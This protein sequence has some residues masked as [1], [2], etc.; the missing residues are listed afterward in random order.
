MQIE[1]QQLGIFAALAGLIAVFAMLQYRPLHGRVQAAEQIKS[2]QL[3]AN[4][5]TEELTKKLP[6]LRSQLEQMQ[7]AVGNYEAKIPAERKIGAFLQE[8]AAVMDAHHLNDQVVQPDSEIEMDGLICIPV[9]IQC[10]GTMS[11]FFEFFKSLKNV[12]RLVRLEQVQLKNDTELSGRVTMTAK[13]NIYYR[14]LKSQA[15][16]GK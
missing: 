2:A 9:K 14:V 3:S 7:A 10:K 5:K 12:E 15:A 16:V 6:M 11:Q 4:A 13:A 8:I 1:K